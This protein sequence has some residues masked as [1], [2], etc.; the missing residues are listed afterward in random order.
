MIFLHK[1][2]FAFYL[3]LLCSNVSPELSRLCM[4]L[5]AMPVFSSWVHSP[6]GLYHDMVPHPLFS[7]IYIFKIID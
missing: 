1:H 5:R 3:Y 7:N 6:N 4:K 2:R